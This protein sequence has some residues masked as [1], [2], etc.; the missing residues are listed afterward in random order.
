MIPVLIAGGIGLYAITKATEP[1]SAGDTGGPA[2]AVAAPGSEVLTESIRAQDARENGFIG[3]A[4]NRT[5]N[6]IYSYNQEVL[7]PDAVS[8][9]KLSDY[10]T[11]VEQSHSAFTANNLKF[12]FD[13]EIAKPIPPKPLTAQP[14]MAVPHPGA[15]IRSGQ[16]IDGRLRLMSSNP[17]VYA[18]NAGPESR[19]K[20]SAG[21]L[22]SQ[23]YGATNNLNYDRW[24]ET[25]MSWAGLRNP[26]RLGGV[27]YDLSAMSTPL[28][29]DQQTGNVPLAHPRNVLE[30]G[31]RPTSVTA[32]PRMQTTARVFNRSVN[33]GRNH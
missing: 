27:H 26:W 2:V 17:Y 30:P 1:P 15:E 3:R 18:E 28:D 32:P 8:V 29:K 21:M 12:T 6:S 4:V 20:E 10:K 14:L 31:G 11:K 5:G 13:Q 23:T 19:I 7:D 25:R 16:N 22:L 24:N 9:L 33:I